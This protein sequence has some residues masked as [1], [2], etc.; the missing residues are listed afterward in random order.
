MHLIDK[1]RQWV[2]S[3]ACRTAST[4]RKEQ[5]IAVNL[6][7]TQ[8]ES[9][10]INDIV[11]AAL[12]DSGLES[13][14]IE[15]EITESLLLG[16][17]EKRMAQLVQLKSRGTSIAMD[18]FVTGYS[19]L[20]Y[21]WQ[22]PFDKIKIDGSFMQSFERSRRNDETVVKSIIAPGREMH[23]RVTVE[24]VETGNQVDFLYDADADLV[25][26]FYFGRPVPA[27]EIGNKTPVTVPK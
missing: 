21:Q 1:I 12:K 24:G 6:S 25:Q 26:G 18:D 22:F 4:W 3:E 14:R 19:S 15:L 8:F 17:N 5:T 2:L 23:M 7:P 27:S 13:H 9:G 20:N 11:E 16:D 10:S